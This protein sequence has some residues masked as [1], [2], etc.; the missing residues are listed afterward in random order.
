MGPRTF[1]TAL[2]VVLAMGVSRYIGATNDALI[3]AML[4]AMAVVMP[5]FKESV[6][7]CVTQI[8]GVVAGALIGVLLMLLPMGPLTT[9][10]L[11]II[12]LI[13]GYH[14]LRIPLPPS[15]PCFILVLICN[16]PGIQPF[17]YA[18][19]RIWDTAIGLGVGMIIN[20]VVFPYDNSKKIAG[21]VESLDSELI[22]FL[23]ELFDGDTILPGSAGMVSKLDNLERQLK[24]FASQYLLLHRRRQKR[25]LDLFQSCNRKARELTAHLQVLEHMDRPG[26]LNE[27]NRRRLAACG[28]RIRDERA[29]DSVLTV[30]VVTNYHVGEILA[31]RREL[32]EALREK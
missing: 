16:T 20:V 15:L 32:L 5:T 2:A 10:W 30:D 17:R 1:K 18:L 27:E 6:N 9:T 3:F 19:G 14:L 24:L 8:L 26:R 29:L 11:G 4:G 21:I 13:T 7:A 25:Q 31:L 23:E 12:I 22:L 28:A